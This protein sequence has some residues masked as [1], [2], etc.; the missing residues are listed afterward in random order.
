MFDDACCASCP[1]GRA[2]VEAEAQIADSRADVARDRT[3]NGGET[4]AW[5]FICRSC[6][7]M[8][9]FQIGSMSSRP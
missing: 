4:D 6:G 9:K 5:T 7:M 1:V 3:C 2:G 8:L